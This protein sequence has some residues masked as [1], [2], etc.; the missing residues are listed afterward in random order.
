MSQTI[1]QKNRMTLYAGACALAL[2]FTP[3]AFA[4]GSGGGAMGGHMGAG[5]SSGAGSHLIQAP[6]TG[7]VRPV[8]S[9]GRP[10][11]GTVR[12]VSAADRPTSIV[13]KPAPT[14]TRLVPN[15]LTTRQV[16]PPPPPSPPTQVSSPTMGTPP[17]RS[18]IP[19]LP[20]RAHPFDPSGHL[21]QSD[22]Q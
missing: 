21:P 3:S 5:S 17:P 2:A 9:A 1:F 12:P 14:G 13:Q 16:D 19:S 10:T 11:S 8:P 22:P 18:S 15:D 7:T 6:Q 20:L 4:L